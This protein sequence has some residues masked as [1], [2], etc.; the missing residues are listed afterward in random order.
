MGKKYAAFQ[1]SGKI[2]GLGYDSDLSPAPNP[3]PSEVDGLLEITQEEWQACLTQRG[4]TVAD[5]AL[6]APAPTADSV[7]LL[8][9]QQAQS[10]ILSSACAQQIISGFASSALGAVHS[11]PSDQRSQINVTLAAQ[12]GGALWCEVGDV[13]SMATHTAEQAQQVQKDLYATVQSAQAKYAALLRQLNETT[14]VESAQA[15]VWNGG[16]E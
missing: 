7:L 11:Y 2:V 9:A 13:W 16:T 6:V 12:N 8:Q 1:K 10:Q 5:G 3:L 15:I 14:T 4:W